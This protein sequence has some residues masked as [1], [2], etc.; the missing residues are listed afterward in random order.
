MFRTCLY[1]VVLSAFT[2][3]FAAASDVGRVKVSSGPVHIERDGERLPAVV[4]TPVRASDTVVTGA[5]ASVGITF[6]DNSR[7]SAGPN[8]T[9]VFNRY[10]F[11]QTTHAGTFDTT[12]KRGTLAVA[13]GRLAKHSPEAM[14]VRTP[15]MVLG[16][17]GTEFL[18]HVE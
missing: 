17:R 16:V 11:D 7:I 4:D 2:A 9:V 5:N 3:P 14:T 1:A 12:L 18:V 6:I 8:S 13:S 10:T 15:T